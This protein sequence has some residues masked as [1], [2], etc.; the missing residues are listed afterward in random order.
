M[1]DLSP[2][3]G[4]V[5]CTIACG[6]A[7]GSED[8][9]GNGSTSSSGGFS[10]ASSGSSSGGSSGTP[11]DAG[12][13]CKIEAIG[14]N[15]GT[16]VQSVPRGS[17]G[18]GG[19]AW[20]DL[21]NAKALDG[22]FAKVVLAAG[23]ESQE[24]RITGFSFKLPTGSVFQGVDVRLDRQAPDGGIADGFIALVG[25]KN[26]NGRGKFIATPWP[27]TI[28]GTHHYAQATDTWGMDLNPP[29]VETV[30]F[31]VGIWVK[32]DPSAPGPA[33][34]TA[35]VDAMRVRVHYCPP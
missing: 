30:D 24:L 29:D 9:N 34:A 12:G 4:F 19:V 18:D 33:S 27:T 35:L 2:L 23:Q 5:A 10:S 26:Q 25:V 16:V 14:F 7:C 22:S 1:K 32:R 6:V 31:G 8:S 13:G 28:V 3:A 20:T 21:D 15:D 17:E 11:T